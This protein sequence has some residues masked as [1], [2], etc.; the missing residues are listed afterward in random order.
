MILESQ[1]LQGL[2]L[3]QTAFRIKEKWK[4]KE[5]WV[6]FHWESTAEVIPIVKKWNNKEELEA[7]IRKLC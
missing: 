4:V 5:S 7:G 1:S 3:E 2:V 6:C